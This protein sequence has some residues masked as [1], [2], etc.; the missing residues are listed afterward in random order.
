[1]KSIIASFILALLGSSV[2]AQDCAWARQF[3]FPTNS[4]AGKVIPDYKGNYF[5]VKSYSSVSS[6]ATN[7]L[8][9]DGKGTTVWS[10]T[11]DVEIT[12]ISLNGDGNLAIA[13]NFR[14]DKQ[15][16]NYTLS[17]SGDGSFIASVSPAG[18]FNWAVTSP[19]PSMTQIHDVS[20][21]NSNNILVLGT[22][23]NSSPGNM[24]PTFLL[25]LN[26][27]NGTLINDLSFAGCRGYELGVDGAGNTIFLGSFYDSLT[28]GNNKLT[29]PQSDYSSQFIC[30]LDKNNTITWLKY[31]GTPIYFGLEGL[32]VSSSG[33][34][35]LMQ[36][37]RYDDFQVKKYDEKCN[38]VWTKLFGGGNY[39]SMT[40]SVWFSGN[41]IFVT[42][43]KWD[44]GPTEVISGL[45]IKLDEAGNTL[46]SNIYPNI[47]SNFI[48]VNKDTLILLA[49]LTQPA[50]I[51]QGTLNPAGGNTVVI[52]FANPPEVSTLSE[53]EMY[54][55]SV[56]PNPSGGLVEI[57][58]E[59]VS[60][61]AEVSVIDIFG[62]VVQ[63]KKA[64]SGHAHFDLSGIA[65]GVYWI[66]VTGEGKPLLKKMLVI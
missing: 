44:S 31:M 26:S 12:D 5:L 9:I 47:E 59:A 58:W 29:V 51:C 56:L 27:S 11:K 8:K 16:G 41:N 10:I 64:A 3:N 22:S 13:G 40:G 14:G 18:A 42:G 60:P 15:L 34:F 23:A 57:K 53:R 45:V 4:T 25:K 7:L 63:H 39:T 46:S 50:N 37:A 61:N 49:S 19:I 17:A 48:S 2:A 52:K 1:M 54:G 28:I 66:K 20:T 62:R 43:R 6:Q 35:C 33:S 65:K 36:G 24:G 55:F 32:S 30:K 21:D 38:V